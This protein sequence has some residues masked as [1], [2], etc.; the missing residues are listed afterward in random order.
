MFHRISVRN[1]SSKVICLKCR[2]ENTYFS[3]R[4]IVTE[5]PTYH[6]QGSSDKIV[7]VALT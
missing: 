3:N 5:W 7:I 4:S 1:R 6:H 2:F